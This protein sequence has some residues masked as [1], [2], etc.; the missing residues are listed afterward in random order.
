M[1]KMQEEGFFGEK[2]SEIIQYPRKERPL[3]A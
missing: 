1:N 3:K 2:K